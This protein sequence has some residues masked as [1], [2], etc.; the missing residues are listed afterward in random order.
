[1]TR[2]KCPL[3]SGPCNAKYS[4]YEV[5]EWASGSCRHGGW[6]EEDNTMPQCEYLSPSERD[7]RKKKS[8]KVFD[9]MTSEHEYRKKRPAKPK[10][11]RK[12]RRKDVDVNDVFL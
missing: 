9:S 12:P 11:K 1:M 4:P 2:R 6:S 5:G 10:P 7:M 8:K 3:D